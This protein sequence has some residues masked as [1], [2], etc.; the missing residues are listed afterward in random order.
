MSIRNDTSIRDSFNKHDKPGSSRRLGKRKKSGIN[1]ATEEQIAQADP[2]KVVDKFR[3]LDAGK[4]DHYANELPELP[5]P[6]TGKRRESCGK[7]VPRGCS[8]CGKTHDTGM[9]CHNR[10]CPRCWKSWDIRRS[11]VWTA[12]LDSLRAKKQAQTGAWYKFHHLVLSPPKGYKL[13]RDNPLEATFEILKE[14]L[15]EIGV[16]TGVLV[17][18]PYRGP[19]SDDRGFWKHALPNGKELSIK[20]LVDSNDLK[21]EP[22]FHCICI[23]P[24]VCTEWVVKHVEEKTGWVI[25][26]I[27]KGE[28][29]SVSL[30]DEYDLAR[31]L[32]YCLS[33]CGQDI[34]GATF[35]PWGEV[36]NHVPKDQAR[37]LREA[38]ATVRSVAV[39]TLGLPYD[40]LACSIERT[41]TETRKVLAP[42]TE[43]IDLGRAM[44][45]AKGKPELEEIEIEVESETEERCNGRLVE[46]KAFPRY[47]ENKE[48]VERAPYADQM[49]EAWEEWRYRVDQLEGAY[50]DKWDTPGEETELEPPP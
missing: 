44:G 29:S 43:E 25:K 16:D 15:G 24:F 27:T 30:Y 49:K 39:N 5:L 47:L 22:H 38:N 33:H 37:R 1:Y 2:S 8:S 26:R 41:K 9:T 46:V 3:R 40:N 11:T 35:R 23:S 19:D 50:P 10:L 14:V 7:A 45:G 48:W 13:N 31:S 18:H 42:A 34:D 36:H 4:S 20:E 17:Y 32:T 6:G 12:K 28:N 21:H